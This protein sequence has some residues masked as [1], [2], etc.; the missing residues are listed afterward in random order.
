MDNPKEYKYSGQSIHVGTRSNLINAN[1]TSHVYLFD[2]TV[3][4][5]KKKSWRLS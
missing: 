5:N 1:Q 2:G 3:L 4:N